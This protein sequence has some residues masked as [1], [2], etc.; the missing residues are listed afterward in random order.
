MRKIGLL[1]LVLV[2]VLLK[3]EGIASAGCTD[4]NVRIVYWAPS[5]FEDVAEGCE[6]SKL[7]MA[8]F[9]ADDLYGFSESEIKVTVDNQFDGTAIDVTDL[10]TNLGTS[11][12]KTL[13]LLGH[14]HL[15]EGGE[16]TYAAMVF[17]NVTSRNNAVADLIYWGWADTLLAVGTTTLDTDPPTTYYTVDLRAAGIDYKLAPGLS[18]EPIVFG[19]YCYSLGN[20]SDFGAFQQ[21]TY[22]GY[23]GKGGVST[24]CTD[25]EVATGALL[26]AYWDTT[27]QSGISNTLGDYQDY[28]LAHAQ[29][30][31]WSGWTISGNAYNRLVCGR[32]CQNIAAILT[33]VEAV[34]CQH[35]SD[36]F[37][38][39][40]NGRS[41]V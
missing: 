12:T 27:T 2:I 23:A 30:P 41:E 11:Q 5:W 25:L 31:W 8:L 6:P 7:T 38:A 33:H 22:V 26:C 24:S 36:S 18:T 21:G 29:V 32:G 34:S 17:D 16:S 9:L 13:F 35:E 40:I 10:V 37:K 4:T 20:S 19:I 15:L 1:A 39:K 14:G 3:S 28:A